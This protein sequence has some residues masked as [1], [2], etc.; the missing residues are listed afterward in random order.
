MLLG[1][2]T[3]NGDRK[4]A[5]FIQ[6]PILNDFFPWHSK[7]GLIPAATPSCVFTLPT[8]NTGRRLPPPPHPPSC[9]QW[10][11]VPSS[12]FFEC[13]YSLNTFVGLCFF[14]VVRTE[15]APPTPDSTV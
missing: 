4:K 8:E 15:T 12:V 2:W 3:Q 10:S 13:V 5:S 6:N 1:Q 9:K 11:P 7:P 14:L